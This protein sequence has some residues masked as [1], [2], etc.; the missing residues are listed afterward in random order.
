MKVD[1]EPFESNRESNASERR[2]T[3][4]QKPARRPRHSNSGQCLMSAD[5]LNRNFVEL[6]NR[7]SASLAMSTDGSFLSRPRQS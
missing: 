3:G 2:W 6:Q 7:W 1:I 5:A 4:Q